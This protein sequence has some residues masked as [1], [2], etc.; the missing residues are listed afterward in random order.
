MV[1]SSSYAGGAGSV[2]RVVDSRASAVVRVAGG[3]PEVVKARRQQ[4]AMAR[5]DRVIPEAA[6]ERRVKVTKQESF[7]RALEELNNMI[8]NYSSICSMQKEKQWE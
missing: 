6:P 8:E 5:N 1:N 3:R 2:P 7:E 4:E